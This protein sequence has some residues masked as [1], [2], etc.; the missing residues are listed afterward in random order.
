MS[1]FSSLLVMAAAALQI[2][3]EYEG[4]ELTDVQTRKLGYDF[5]RCV[6]KAQ[7]NLARRVILENLSTSEIFRKHAGLSD[8]NCLVDAWPVQHVDG[9]QMR[10]PGDLM[11]YSLADALVER[12]YP[13][14]LPNVTARPPLF[15]RPVDPVLFQPR[16]GKKLNQA[17]I[18]TLARGKA[19]AIKFYYLARFGECVVRSNSAG[20]H[21]LVMQKPGS[22]EE[23]AAFAALQPALNNCLEAG[24]TFT[25]NYTLLRGTVALNAYRLA[26]SASASEAGK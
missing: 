13:K 9:V 7:S 4:A 17:Q 23:R 1:L 21:R 22:P 18:E 26:R 14:G 25:A 24:Q 15:H 12:E 5:G 2:P 20:T 6:L 16:P 19:T 8:S 10:M 3:P 11:R